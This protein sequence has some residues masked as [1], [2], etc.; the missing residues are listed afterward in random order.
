MD[1]KIPSGSFFSQLAFVPYDFR[2]IPSFN[3]NVLVYL[4][5]ASQGLVAS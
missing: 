2:G 3:T 1:D 5:A 4:P